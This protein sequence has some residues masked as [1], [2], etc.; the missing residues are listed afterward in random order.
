MRIL[1]ALCVAFSGVIAFAARAQIGP[2]TPPPGCVVATDG[3]VI[4]TNTTLCS[5]DYILPHGI[6]ICG[7]NITLDLNG[8]GIF[9]SL[10]SCA[11]PPPDS[12]GVR[13]IGGDPF[14]NADRPRVTNITI[15]NG[16]IGWYRVGVPVE[17]ADGV[18]IL[19]NYLTDNYQR[20]PG[21]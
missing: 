11:L 13:C 16:M 7:S 15:K 8:A 14:C 19:N 5:R 2:G 21:P 9:Q 1:S 4:T 18:N 20:T 3:M 10:N 12:C 17:H 6:F